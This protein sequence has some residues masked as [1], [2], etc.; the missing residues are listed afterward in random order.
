MQE[1]TRLDWF[2]LASE[3]DDGGEGRYEAWANQK[4]VEA[5]ED[6]VRHP[7]EINSLRLVK[8]RRMVKMSFLNKE[9][10]VGK[11]AKDTNK[12]LCPRCLGG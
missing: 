12:G 6:T 2:D 7:G 8:E 1:G 11:E 3:P 5:A 9:R 4:V 10:L